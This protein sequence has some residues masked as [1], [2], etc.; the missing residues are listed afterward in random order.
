[1][2][3][4]PEKA[5]ELIDYFLNNQRP[6]GWY[7]WAEVVWNNYRTP[8]SLEICLTHGLVAILLMPLEQCLYTRMK[9]INPLFLVLHFTQIGLIQKMEYP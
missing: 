8:N 6:Q 3:N 1:M 5:H 9:K 2:L 4:E 7:H